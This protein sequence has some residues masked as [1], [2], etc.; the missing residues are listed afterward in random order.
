[1]DLE[2]ETERNSFYRRIIYTSK[3]S[4]IALMSIPAN[5]TIPEESHE[6][7]QFIR[8][9]KGEILVEFK[10]GS[11]SN[12]ASAKVGPGQALCISFKEV[13]KV[14]ALED[15]KLYTIYSFSDNKPEHN[16]GEIAATEE[17][18]KKIEKRDK[19][20]VY[21]EKRDTNDAFNLL[22]KKYQ[23]DED[24]TEDEDY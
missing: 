17:E 11:V 24:Q 19:V 21:Q 13:H 3:N 7:D 15:T 8:V 1:M 16:K 5:G 12:I 4:Q 10:V 2:N 20:V 23:S 6:G 9:E 22:V 14:K 18:S